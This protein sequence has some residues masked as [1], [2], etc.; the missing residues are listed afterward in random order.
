MFRLLAAL[1]PPDTFFLSI[2]LFRLPGDVAETLD[3]VVHEPPYH[4][5][6][7]YSLL[8]LFFLLLA[9]SFLLGYSLDCTLLF[10][11][12]TLK[13][14]VGMVFTVQLIIIFFCVN[15][16]LQRCYFGIGVVP[17]I[18]RFS[19]LWVPTYQKLRI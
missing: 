10:T 6:D 8:L 11:I 2:P 19:K 1:L 3:G 16:V 18:V 5:F 9:F 17:A 7:D 12:V 4:L 14:I 13:H 15:Y